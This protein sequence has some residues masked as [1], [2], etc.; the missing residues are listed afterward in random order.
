MGGEAVASHDSV[1][2]AEGGEAIVRRAV[3][4]FGRVDIVINNAGILRDR[5][6][7]EDGP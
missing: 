6:L 7:V 1:A 5:Q 4:A 2:T 3:E